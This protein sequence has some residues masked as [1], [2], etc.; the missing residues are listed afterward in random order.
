[1]TRIFE[2]EADNIFP[3]RL[4]KYI[5]TKSSLPSAPPSRSALKARG[6][7]VFVNGKAAKLSQMVRTPDSVRVE[8][9]EEDETNIT[10]EDIPLDVIYEDDDVTV[11]NKAQGMVV[12]PAAGHWHGTLANALLGRA[13]AGRRGDGDGDSDSDSDED[14][15]RGGNNTSCCS[16]AGGNG[17]SGGNTAGASG[18]A[19]CDARVRAGIVHRLDKD[20]S[21]VIITAKSYD[22]LLYLQ[23]QF[24][25]HTVRKEYIAIVKGRP[26]A[27]AGII[28]CRIARSKRDRKKFAVT[29]DEALGRSAKTLYRLTACYGPYSVMRL[30]LK[31]GRT[32]QIRVHLKHI[33][34]PILGDAIYSSRD[35]L[36][37]E[38]TLMLHSRL[39]EIN[40]PL[41]NKRALFIAPLPKRFK[42]VLRALKQRYARTL[43]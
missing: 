2:S 34:C 10:G 41:D 20:T 25:A 23:S 33:H 27:A 42:A 9:L 26:P 21:G 5:A 39:L 37:P 31:T 38:A 22:A 11:I 6:A 32:H 30:R 40:L 24:K 28:E 13:A 18:A 17:T 29:E 35:D 4:D 3:M 19:S 14:S 16:T 1:M 36:F 7:A 43:P 12:H 15:T 8:W